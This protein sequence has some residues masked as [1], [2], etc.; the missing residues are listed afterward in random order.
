MRKFTRFFLLAVVTVLVLASCS[1]KKNTAAT[2]WWHSFTARYNT[3]FN[4]HQAFLEG[5]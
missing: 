2:R 4:G 1:T 5:E 3:F